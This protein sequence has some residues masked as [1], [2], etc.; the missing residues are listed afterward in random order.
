MTEFFP[1]IHFDSSVSNCAFEKRKLGG[2][3]GLDNLSETSVMQMMLFP[4][5]V[6][7]SELDSS[8]KIISCA[9]K[10]KHPFESYSGFLSL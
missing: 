2:I 5:A 7:M 3:G 6:S 8:S 1:D 10:N 4:R 9:R